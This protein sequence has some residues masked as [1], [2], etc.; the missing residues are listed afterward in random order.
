MKIIKDW[1]QLQ[2]WKP[3]IKL[4]D[5]LLASLKLGRLKVILW[6]RKKLFSVGSFLNRNYQYVNLPQK[7]AY[8][9]LWPLE[10]R[11]VIK[12]ARPEGQTKLQSE[13]QRR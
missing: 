2:L 1:F 5:S 8:L 11:W 6:P 7:E 10:L 3:E 13:Q 4:Q 12:S 9:I